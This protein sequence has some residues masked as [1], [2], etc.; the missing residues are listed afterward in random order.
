MY[1]LH[2]KEPITII[3]DGK[4]ILLNQPTY[5]ISDEKLMKDNGLFKCWKCKDY[6]DEIMEHG[7]MHPKND[8]RE[9]CET[10]FPG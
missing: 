4:E 10:H 8:G 5:N 9:Y 2:L 6:F 1:K 3:K 7:S